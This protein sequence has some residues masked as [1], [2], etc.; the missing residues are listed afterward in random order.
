MDANLGSL[1]VDPATK[2]KLLQLVGTAVAGAIGGNAAA[3]TAG[4]ADAYNRQ[5]HKDPNPKK[6][7]EKALAKLQEGKS[8]EERQR[9]ADAACALMRCAG[10]LSESNPDNAAAIASQERGAN[11]KDEQRQLLATGLFQYSGTDAAKDA[12]S[13]TLDWGVSGAIRGAANLAD[14]LGRDIAN[15]PHDVVSQAPRND[16]P[17]GDANSQIDPNG[18]GPRTPS[19]PAG[20]TVVVGAMPCGLGLL[21]PTVNAAPGT[22]WPSIAIASS[23]NDN[24][25]GG[26]QNNDS[27]ANGGVAGDATGPSKSPGSGGQAANAVGAAREQ[28]VAEVVGGQRSGELIRT[29]RGKTDIDVVDSAG[30]IYAVGGAAKAKDLVVS[31]SR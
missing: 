29:S 15:F 31:S 25:S 19:G 4:M 2:D 16:V 20:A 9:L 17:Q 30:N 8:P 3:A 28:R 11:Y 14:K 1:G 5:P 6:D 18:G 22:G 27:S 13:R 26:S 7:E 12:G 23:G 24:S 21:C 10:E